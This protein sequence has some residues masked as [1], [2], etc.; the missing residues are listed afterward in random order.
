MVGSKRVTE[1]VRRHTHGLCKVGDDLRVGDLLVVGCSHG[2]RL[3][4]LALLCIRQKASWSGWADE[5]ECIRVCVCAFI[6]YRVL[7]I[8]VSA[9]L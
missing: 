4:R 2:Q 3:W 7:G 5:L 6:S 9:L 8:D 1:P